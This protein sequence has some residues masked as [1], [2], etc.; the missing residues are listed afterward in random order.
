MTQGAR[1]GGTGLGGRAELGRIHLSTSAS[2]T[3][4][5]E[6]GSPLPV[7]RGLVYVQPPSSNWIFEGNWGGGSGG[8]ADV[9]TN[10]SSRT[11]ESSRAGS[12]YLRE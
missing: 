5:R 1:G 9:Q 10:P 8:C 11:R 7:L 3:G 6:R 12:S 2:P 4:R